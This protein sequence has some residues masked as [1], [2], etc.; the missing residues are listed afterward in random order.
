M[1]ILIKSVLNTGSQFLKALCNLFVIPAPTTSFEDRRWRESRNAPATQTRNVTHLWVP[2]F[3]GTT[4]LYLCSKV[5]VPSENITA[6]SCER[7]R[8]DSSLFVLAC[9]RPAPCRKKPRRPF[10]L[11][12]PPG[13]DTVNYFNTSL[14][15]AAA[16]SASAS[17]F[18]RK[19]RDIA[20]A[21]AFF[22]ASTY[23][24]WE[25]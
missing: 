7:S 14:A 19:P 8:A 4:S 22:T 5:Q 21:A 25:P 12:N 6:S 2:V 17:S 3:T 1:Q 20:F 9:D 11:R 13:D 24:A 10:R 15:S 18:S 23:P 16:I